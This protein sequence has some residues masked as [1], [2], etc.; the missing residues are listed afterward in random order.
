MGATA[1]EAGFDVYDIHVS[2][3]APVMGATSEVARPP[4]APALFQSTRP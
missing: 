2:I 1:R 4:M 3:H